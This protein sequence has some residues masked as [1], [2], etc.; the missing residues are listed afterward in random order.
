MVTKYAALGII[1]SL[2]SDG[3]AVM[4]F[5]GGL[6]IVTNFGANYNYIPAGEGIAPQAYIHCRL[7]S[8]FQT[9]RP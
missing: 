2:Q 3:T 5:G 9:C 6:H 8:V 4:D 7:M 1:V